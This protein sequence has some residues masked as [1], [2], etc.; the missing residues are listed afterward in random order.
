MRPKVTITDKRLF[1]EMAR[2]IMDLPVLAEKLQ[3]TFRNSLELANLLKR[4]EYM[5]LWTPDAANYIPRDA[6]IVLLTSAFV[7]SPEDEERGLEWK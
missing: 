1:W 2:S 6:S 4:P 7:D 5:I 3:E